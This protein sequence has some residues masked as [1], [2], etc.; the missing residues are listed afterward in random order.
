MLAVVAA[1]AERLAETV[2]PSSMTVP[3]RED[4]SS[5][6]AGRDTAGPIVAAAAE[7]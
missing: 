4:S 7:L 1:L 3:A 5:E 2:V 6:L